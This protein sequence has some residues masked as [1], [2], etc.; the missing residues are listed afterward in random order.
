M[1]NENFAPLLEKQTRS[2]EQV[3]CSLKK[4][5]QANERPAPRVVRGEGN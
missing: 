1:A 5:L 4:V 2:S 3:F